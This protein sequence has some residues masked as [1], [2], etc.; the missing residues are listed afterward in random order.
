MVTGEQIRE[1]CKIHEDEEL[2]TNMQ[3]DTAGV[4]IRAALAG[5]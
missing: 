4:V 5:T 3:Y 1:C 2:S